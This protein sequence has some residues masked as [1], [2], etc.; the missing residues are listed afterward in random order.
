M[1]IDTSVVLAIL[2][3]SPLMVEQLLARFREH[4]A[5]AVDARRGELLCSGWGG[6]SGHKAETVGARIGDYGFKRLLFMDIP[7]EPEASP[8]FALARVLS[9]SSRIPLYMGGSIRTVEHL[10]QAREV[11]GIHGL[12]VDGILL[13]A[14]R[15]LLAASSPSGC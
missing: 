7:P 3:R 14:D 10:A 11:S 9:L 13:R 1:V 15:A 8:D 6:P 2:Q 5:A 12:A 4:L